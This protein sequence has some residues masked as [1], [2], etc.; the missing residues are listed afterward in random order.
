MK[1]GRPQISVLLRTAVLKN[2]GR[3][4]KG[5]LGTIPKARSHLYWILHILMDCLWSS[6]GLPRDCQ[7]VPEIIAVIH[8]VKSPS[9]CPNSFVAKSLP[10]SLFISH[11]A[12]LRY[13]SF[14][15]RF[16]SRVPAFFRGLVNPRAPSSSREASSKSQFPL[17]TRLD[18]SQTSPSLQQFFNALH[19]SHQQSRHNQPRI[20]SYCLILTESTMA[21]MP[22]SKMAILL[23]R[24][25]RIKRTHPPDRAGESITEVEIWRLVYDNQRKIK[26]SMPDVPDEIQRAL[27]EQ[28]TFEDCCTF[29]DLMSLK[30]KLIVP[31]GARTSHV[32][33]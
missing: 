2:S 28:Q 26:N 25:S 30:L 29:V 4:L 27:A 1:N 22:P 10:L 6:L 24:A 31:R 8:A 5:M 19:L 9:H 33:C 16:C 17:S 12:Q 21:P 3:L 32:C 13:S 20:N 14:I 15:F 11:P 7:I 23:D 18:S